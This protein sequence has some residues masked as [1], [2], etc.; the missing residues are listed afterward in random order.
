[1]ESDTQRYRKASEIYHFMPN[2]AIWSC[3]HDSGNG[4]GCVAKKSRNIRQRR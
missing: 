1:M 4:I 3:S 2:A